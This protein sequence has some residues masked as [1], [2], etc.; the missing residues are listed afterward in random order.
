[1]PSL[2][3]PYSYLQGEVAAGASMAQTTYSGETRTAAG[4]ASCSARARRAAPAPSAARRLSLVSIDALPL[5]PCR[6][7]CRAGHTFVW[8][9]VDHALSSGVEPKPHQYIKIVD[10]VNEYEYHGHSTSEL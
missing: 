10:G 1:M 4:C 9:D 3:P 8:R 2:A 7:F 6:F 5:R